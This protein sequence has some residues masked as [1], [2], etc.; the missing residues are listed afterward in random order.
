VTHGGWSV[1]AGFVDI[2]VDGWLDLAVVNYID[3]SPQREIDCRAMGDAR[4]YCSPVRYRA[5]KASALFRNRGDGT[6]EDAS[7][8]L[9]LRSAVGNGLGIAA[10]RFAKRDRPGLFV[11]ND[12][13]PNHLWLAGEGGR[14]REESLMLGCA[15]N[16]I[17]FAASGMGV[18]AADVENDGDLD[19]FVSH[20]R[21]QGSALYVENDGFFLDQAARAGLL[22]PS[23][24]YTGFGTGFAD[25]DQD[26][27]L[28]LYVANG[29]VALEEPITDPR[30]PYAEES[31][32]FEN[33]G[34]GRFAEVLPRG[35]V[36]PSLART[37]RAAAF[38]DLDGDGDVD[39][40][41]VHRDAPISLLRNQA[42]RGHWIG[43]RV[44]EH[45]RDAIGARVELRAGGTTQYR[46][47][48]TAYSYAASNDPRVHFGVGG[49]MKV[50][51]IRVRWLDGSEEDFGARDADR[52]H[53]LRRK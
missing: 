33:T 29:R 28:D 6:F 48:Q 17:G 38:G 26:G 51:S 34:D 12:M 37:S 4:D 11:A 50:D 8:R 1:S 30:D 27:D 13:T 14:M 31:Q 5:P 18:H 10:G 39:I 44:I 49:A 9:G 25:F 46:D 22:R 15:L 24:P 35:G 32:L 47:V 45:G 23:L 53:E 41:V 2:D 7:E 3:W 20:L 16:A 43:L 21:R 36:W 52:Y 40:V 42:A 19:V